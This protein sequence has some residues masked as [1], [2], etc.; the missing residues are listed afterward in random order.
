[1]SAYKSDALVVLGGGTNKQGESD[2]I[3]VVGGYWLMTD[4]SDKP[5]GSEADQ[6]E[7]HGLTR[8]V[9]QKDIIKAA[10]ESRETIGNAVFAKQEV[11]EP[12]GWRKVD[13]V[14]SVTH[15]P[16]SLKGFKHVLG[17]EYQLYGFEAEEKWLLPKRAYEVLGSLMQDY[18]LDGTEPGD[19][20]AIRHRL[21]ERVPGYGNQVTTAQLAYNSLRHAAGLKTS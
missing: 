14:T 1:M 10:I 18:V 7:D 8:G 17:P 12:N 5:V 4:E 6:M 3:I 13:V 19:D 16:R 11:L 2:R 21:V 9:P 20:E 15:L